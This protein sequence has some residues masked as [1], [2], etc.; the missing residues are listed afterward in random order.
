ME[1]P[2]LDAVY[3][4]YHVR[5]LDMI[6]VRADRACDRCEVSEVMESFIWRR[7]WRTPKSM[8]SATIENASSPG[9]I[10]IQDKLENNKEDILP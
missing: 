10:L 7:C 3:H 6:G 1:V 4:R 5:A 2:T 9:C 8:A